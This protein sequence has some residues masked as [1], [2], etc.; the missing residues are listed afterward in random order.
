MKMSPYST[1]IQVNTYIYEF[2][3]FRDV[4]FLKKNYLKNIELT[5][6]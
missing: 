4:I 1:R 3:Y 2:N 5:I 6:N